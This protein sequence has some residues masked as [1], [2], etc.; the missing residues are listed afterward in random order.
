MIW[1]SWQ[2]RWLGQG[3]G[4]SKEAPECVQQV[5]QACTCPG[6]GI[7]NSHCCLPAGWCTHTAGGPAPLH[8]LPPSVQR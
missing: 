4:R 5:L 3:T 6:P 1:R 7:C 2:V 8:L